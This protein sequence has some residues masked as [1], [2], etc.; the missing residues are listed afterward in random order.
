MRTKKSRYGRVTGE[1]LKL[2]A[3]MRNLVQ[4]RHEVS[5]EVKEAWRKINPTGSLDPQECDSD[6]LAR[7]KKAVEVAC[8][9][10]PHLKQKE[11]SG[12]M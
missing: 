4:R 10:G 2:Y 5:G 6:D 3:D 1:I 12:S 7:Y 8:A 9:E 11:S